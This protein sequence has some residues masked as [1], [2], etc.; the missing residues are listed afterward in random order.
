[1]PVGFAVPAGV[2]A[3]VAEAVEETRE[4]CLLVWSVVDASDCCDFEETLVVPLTESVLANANDEGGRTFG[5]EEMEA[6]T[7]VE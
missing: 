4:A 2:T 6:A 5:L 7:L 3:E 1:M